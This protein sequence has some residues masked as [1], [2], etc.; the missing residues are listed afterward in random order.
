MFQ[1]GQQIPSVLPPDFLLPV[2][3]GSPLNTSLRCLSG[4]FTLDGVTPVVVPVAAIT[5]DSFVLIGLNTPAGTVGAAP[6]VQ[7]KIA[8]ASFT[9]LGTALDTS[10]YRFLILG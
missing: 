8:G 4:T 7:S 10:I 9:V 1:S 6:V 3:N 5:A 2:D